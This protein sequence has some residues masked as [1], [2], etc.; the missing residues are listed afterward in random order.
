MMD[1][2]KE[3]A[4]D[5]ARTD[6]PD[7]GT[8]HAWLDGALDAAPAAAIEAHMASCPSCADRAAEA[9]GLIAG[10]SRIVA[11][12]D[13][14]PGAGAPAWGRS[15]EALPTRRSVWSRL[16]V[17]PVR[18][19]LAAAIVV[20]L[21]ITLTRTR[22]GLDS[23]REAQ[24]TAVVHATVANA[25]AEKA[26]EDLLADTLAPRRVAA[27]RAEM[28]TTTETT[29]A[30]ADRAAAEGMIA[31]RAA[32]AAG[33]ITRAAKKADAVT[34]LPAP[35][36]AAVAAAPS[37]RTAA[38]CYRV[39]SAS[40]VAATWG[41]VP[42][43]FVVSVDTVARSA[44]LFDT[45]GVRAAQRVSWTRHTGDSLILT[46]RARDY[47]GTLDLGTG[48]TARPGVMRSVETAGE[49]TGGANEAPPGV[50]LRGTSP[51][52]AR[53]RAAAP[54]PGAA[55]PAAPATAVVARRV[56]CPAP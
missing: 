26:K 43:P 47:G 37:P 41:S 1:R 21:G 5:A 51:A 22:P 6:H 28:S 9:R 36:V 15:T 7:E 54:A 44:R 53:A 11:A 24:K 10:A 18:A 23:V 14:A 27:A 55:P 39:E 12:L 4:M 30:R 3:T 32:P 20:A 31:G 33:D 48:T 8:I 49:A 52:R 16:R 42:L 56:A 19:A 38:E 25:P 45:S 13:D 2:T 29:G 35:Q 46:L 17:T 34:T 40:G 50:V